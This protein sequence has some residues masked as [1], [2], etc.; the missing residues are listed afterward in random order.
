MRNKRT[1]KITDAQRDE[2]IAKR[3]AKV[4]VADIA[5]EYG[6]TERYVYSL[7]NY[8]FARRPRFAFNPPVTTPKAVV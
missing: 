4:P 2:V 1:Q 7:A 6:I 3:R 5:S 8:G